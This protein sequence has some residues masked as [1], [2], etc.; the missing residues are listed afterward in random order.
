M[1]KILER[2]RSIAW[3]YAPQDSAACEELAHRIADAGRREQLINYSDLVRNVT[4][5]LPTLREP[6]HRIDTADWQELDRA[7]IGDFL[8]YLSMESY[9]RGGFLASALVVGKETRLPGEGF[10]NLLKELGLIKSSKTD[11]AA[12]LWADHVQKA[13]DWYR[14]N[15]SA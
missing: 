15:S 1:D 13:Q 9:E 11:K 4:F 2:F 12:Y 3:R 6:E 8:G 7:I 14:S 5:H 10:Y